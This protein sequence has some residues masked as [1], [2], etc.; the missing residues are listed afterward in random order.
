VLVSQRVGKLMGDDQIK[1]PGIAALHDEQFLLPVVIKGRC[2]FCQQI[3][4]RGK[5]IEIL[6]YEAKFP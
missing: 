5:E 3:H 1:G 4:R 2:L 6:G